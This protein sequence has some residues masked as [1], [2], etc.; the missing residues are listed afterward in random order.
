MDGGNDHRG[1]G[2]TM[3]RT[4]GLLSPVMF[5]HYSHL[6]R[7]SFSVSPVCELQVLGLKSCPPSATEGSPDLRFCK[8]TT[9]K[10]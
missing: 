3:L 7:Q 6:M 9:E 2:E 8:A 1:Q 4:S 5:S 10:R